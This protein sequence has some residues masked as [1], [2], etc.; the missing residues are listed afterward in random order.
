MT[1]VADKIRTPELDMKLRW[2]DQLIN[3]LILQS[4]FV[5]VLSVGVN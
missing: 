2:Y 1:S 4:V 5:F 3:G